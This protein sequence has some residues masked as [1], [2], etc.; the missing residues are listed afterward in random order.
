MLFH[1]V[2]ISLFRSWNNREVYDFKGV[3][4]KTTD[5][6]YSYREVRHRWRARELRDT[7]ESHYA[8]PMWCIN[9]P[10]R[11][12]GAGC[13]RTAEVAICIDVHHRE[14]DLWCTLKSLSHTQIFVASIRGISSG[15]Q[16][17]NR[18]FYRFQQINAL[19]M[20]TLTHTLCISLYI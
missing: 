3:R 11:I 12:Q 9:G 20:H 13:R 14:C 10:C 4:E 19:K 17:T 7:E 8:M 18:D 2:K 16:L 5:V 6:C 1:Y 15:S